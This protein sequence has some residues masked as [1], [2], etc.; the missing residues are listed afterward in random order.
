M[1]NWNEPNME[2]RS[3]IR[4]SGEGEVTEA[5]VAKLVEL[6]SFEKFSRL[7]FPFFY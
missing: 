4:F 1:D 6:L 3:Q 2:D 7:F 5:S